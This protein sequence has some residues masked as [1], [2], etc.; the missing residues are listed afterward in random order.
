MTLEELDK[1]LEEMKYEERGMEEKSM[2]HK[3]IKRVSNDENPK[4]DKRNNDCP[5]GEGEE[6]E[7]VSNETLKEELSKVRYQNVLMLARIEQM[8]E[9]AMDYEKQIKMLK[10]IVKEKE[11]DEIKSVSDNEDE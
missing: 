9:E 10:E 2:V 3:S 6:V 1:I 8:E 4:E 11:E 7:D 5:G